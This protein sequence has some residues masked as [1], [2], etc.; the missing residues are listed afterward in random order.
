M[1]NE[2]S[3]TQKERYYV[4]LCI[5]EGR[6]GWSGEEGREVGREREEGEKKM[7]KRKNQVHRS[8]KEKDA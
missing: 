8:T 5:L 6:E 7:T 4:I 1:L 2:T 3:Q